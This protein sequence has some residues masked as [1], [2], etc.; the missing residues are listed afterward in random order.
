MQASELS[1]LRQNSER[2]RT[3]KCVRELAQSEQR[4]PREAS[5]AREGPNRAALEGLGLG[6]GVLCKVCFRGYKEARRS[7]VTLQ[8]HLDRRKPPARQ[9]RTAT[10]KK[11]PM[12]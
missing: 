7:W 2:V 5:W 10:H 1:A 4:T 8:R 11:A 12:P 6:W 9:L 3:Q